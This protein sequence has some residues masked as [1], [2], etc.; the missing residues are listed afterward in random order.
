MRAHLKGEAFPFVPCQGWCRELDR[1]PALG[2]GR[3]QLLSALG[4]LQCPPPTTLRALLS[5][6]GVIKPLWD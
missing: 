4:V 6:K 3:E 1:G 5:D 2:T